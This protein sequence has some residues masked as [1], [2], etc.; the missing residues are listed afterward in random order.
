MRLERIRPTVLRATLHVHELAALMTA[1]RTV[2]DGAPE[3][4][5][6]EARGQ[7]RTLL[8]DYDEQVRHLGAQPGTGRVP[9]QEGPTAR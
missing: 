8:E 3:E 2:V 9:P 6:Q 1:V 7:L 4:V 5:P